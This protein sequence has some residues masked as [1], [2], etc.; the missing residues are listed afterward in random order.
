M[1]DDSKGPERRKSERRQIADRRKMP[2][3][4]RRGPD[5]GRR[6]EDQIRGGTDKTAADVV[7]E[8]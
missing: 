6:K 7:S 5:P 8:E 4:K 3:R 1:S 2:A